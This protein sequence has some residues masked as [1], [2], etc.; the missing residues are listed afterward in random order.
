MRLQSNTQPLYGFTGDYIIPKGTIE[1]LVTIGDRPQT[2]TVMSKFLV[3]KGG[4]QYNVIIR[5]LTLRALKVITLIY[6]Q[7]IKFPDP[8]GIGKV[9]GNQYDSRLTYS[10]T[11]HYYVKPVQM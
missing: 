10:E 5:R 4:D 11:V 7:M 6:H 1:L 9:R 3:V 2:S 8:N